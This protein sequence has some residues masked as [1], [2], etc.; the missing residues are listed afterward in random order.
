MINSK[1]IIG[2]KPMAHL[3]KDYNFGFPLKNIQQ[4]DG[5][6]QNILSDD[7]YA[8]SLVKQII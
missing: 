4:L 2:V 6:E 8:T 7:K 1:K 5:I 3:I